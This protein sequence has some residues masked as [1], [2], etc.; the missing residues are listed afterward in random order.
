MLRDQ[1]YPVKVDNANRTAVLDQ[2]GEI[3]LRAA[4]ALGKENNVSRAKMAWLSNKDATKAY[5]SMVIYVANDSCCSISNDQPTLLLTISDA[6][7][8]IGNVSYV[9]R[10]MTSNSCMILFNITISIT[11][12]DEPIQPGRF[13]AAIEEM[14]GSKEDIS[15]RTRWE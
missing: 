13:A 6:L 9:V 2:D 12:S 3:L 7:I 4:E 8:I 10:I 11:T 14:Q 1:L 15:T 5:V